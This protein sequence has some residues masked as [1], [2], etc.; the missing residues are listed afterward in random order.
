MSLKE[1]K[2][3][4][5]ADHSGVLMCA[6]E[7]RREGNTVLISLWDSICIQDARKETATV[8][9]KSMHFMSLFRG[10]DREW[11]WN[12]YVN[13]STRKGM[14]SCTTQ[15]GKLPFSQILFPHQVIQLLR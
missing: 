15:K 1:N 9:M 8:K 12:V 14:N 2:K 11:I 5:S 3:R 6:A 13:K 4:H 7:V 10:E